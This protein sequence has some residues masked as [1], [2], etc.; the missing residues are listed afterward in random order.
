MRFLPFH[1]SIH[2]ALVRTGFNPRLEITYLPL[3]MPRSKLLGEVVDHL[4]DKWN[5]AF[6]MN[7]KED[8]TVVLISRWEDRFVEHHDLCLTVGDVCMSLEWSGAPVLY[9]GMKTVSQVKQDKAAGR[10]CAEPPLDEGSL[11]SI[12]HLD[13]LPGSPK[14][15][16]PE[17][18]SL[19]TSLRKDESHLTTSPFR[20][21]FSS[22]KGDAFSKCEEDFRSAAPAHTPEFSFASNLSEFRHQDDNSISRMLALSRHNYP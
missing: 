6:V 22:S 8:V 4:N 3:R 18:Q 1:A 14:S 7:Q 17:G 19:F 10:V 5:P 12:R 20:N 15:L 21:L 16:E 9:Y 11:P 2:A 13:A